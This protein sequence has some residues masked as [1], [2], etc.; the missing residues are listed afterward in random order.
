[1]IVSASVVI[2]MAATADSPTINRTGDS[3]LSDEMMGERVAGER[4]NW[5]VITTQGADNQ[6]YS[7][8]LLAIN[9][10]G[11]VVYRNDTYDVYF[12]VDPSPAGKRTV[13]YVASKDR[14][15]STVNHI[16][17]INLTTGNTETLYSGI[18]PNVHHSRWHDADRINSTH[19][20]VA[21]IERDRVFI[22]DIESDQIVWQWYA[23]QS[24]SA[25]SG[26]PG[27]DWTHLN[28]VEVLADGKIMVSL[29]NQDQVIA[30]HQNGTVDED[31]TLGADGRHS[32]IYEQ[33]NPD[34]IPSKNGGPA[35]LVSD[36][37]NGRIVEYQRVNRDWK[38][39][40][41]WTDRRLTWPRDADR[42]PNGHTLIVDSL[43][44]R[45]IEV[46]RSGTVV[47]NVSVG[48]PYDAERIGTGGESEG[49]PS[50]AESGLQ[51]QSGGVDWVSDFLPSKIYHGLQWLIPWWAGTSSVVA[52]LAYTIASIVL[53]SSYLNDS[54]RSP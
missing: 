15:D 19:Y 30:L 14:Q 24:Y 32:T 28:D 2:V 48:I 35:V 36:S 13:Q 41:V 40:W 8:E 6:G 43:G 37:E 44:D 10:S 11:H 9:D 49:G 23:N 52:G 22:V 33:H 21:G 53:A 39:T 25:D 45:V 31:W 26:G 47:W 51:S 50:A 3:N 20:V 12:D 27:D 5:T 18:T 34:Y 54:L 1:M 7:A 38:Q 46:D 4:G 29:R 42:L 16:E 17:Q